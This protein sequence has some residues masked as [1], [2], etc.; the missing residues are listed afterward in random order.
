MTYSMYPEATKTLKVFP[1]VDDGWGRPRCPYCDKGMNPSGNK[2]SHF[3]H[4]FGREDNTFFHCEN[5]DKFGLINGLQYGPDCLLCNQEKFP[6]QITHGLCSDC[7]IKRVCPECNPEQWTDRETN[8]VE[9]P[10]ITKWYL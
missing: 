8:I 5:C 3:V 4:D 9:N 6:H 7:H 10:Y 2:A 1:Y